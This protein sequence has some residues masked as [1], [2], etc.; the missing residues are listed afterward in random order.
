MEGIG[1]VRR[2][3]MDIGNGTG[4]LKRIASTRMPTKWGL[5]KAIGYLQDGANGSAALAMTPGDPTK[6][7]TPLLRIHTQCVTGEILGS[8]RCD[9][10]EQLAVA[11]QA[12]AA[13]GCGLVIYEYQ[14]GR[15]IGQ[16]FSL[17]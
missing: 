13:E 10:G 4:P 9:C 1:R 2:N 3:R 7:A 14:E 17:A 6:V 8:L 15:G 11:M 5:F 12:I 16:E